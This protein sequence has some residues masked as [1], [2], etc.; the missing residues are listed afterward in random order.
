MLVG[1]R[2]GIS[3]RWVVISLRWCFEL[4]KPLRVV[5]MGEIM[6]KCDEDRK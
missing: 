5:E 4:V 6:C 3:L 1:R 2:E